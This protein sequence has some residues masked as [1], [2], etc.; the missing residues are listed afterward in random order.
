M[1]QASGGVYFLY[2]TDLSLWYL[3][4]RPLVSRTPLMCTQKISIGFRSR[5]SYMSLTYNSTF[6][7]IY[8]SQKFR[9][10]MIKC[11]VYPL[12]NN[13][14]FLYVLSRTNSSNLVG[15][16][17]SKTRTLHRS[18]VR[19]PVRFHQR[20]TK[21]TCPSVHGKFLLE[22]KTGNDIETAFILGMW[23]LKMPSRVNEFLWMNNS[24][25]E[26]CRLLVV[27]WSIK[28]SQ[29]EQSFAF[30]NWAFCIWRCVCV[31][32]AHIAPHIMTAINV[33][34]YCSHVCSRSCWK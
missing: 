26:K 2:S 11:A 28:S 8:G 9:T 10:T 4:R 22:F 31:P 1:L 30:I 7:G 33:D 12:C 24:N 27:L 15:V 34:G 25:V 21:N 18:N 20:K 19:Q 14:M 5:E 3:P 23:V 29:R 16:C 32:H 13:Y 6:R 17:S